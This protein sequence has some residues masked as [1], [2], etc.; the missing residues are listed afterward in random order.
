MLVSTTMP[1]ILNFLPRLTF[2]ER[3]SS[4]ARSLSAPTAC[5]PITFAQR[6]RVVSSGDLSK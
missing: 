2:N 6:M 4:T 3:A 5:E 1:S